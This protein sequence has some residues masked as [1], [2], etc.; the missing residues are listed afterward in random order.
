MSGLHGGS[1]GWKG[2]A[3]L[4]DSKDFSG[5]ATEGLVAIA[6]SDIAGQVR[7]KAFPADQL[8][9]RRRFGGGW[10]PSNVMINCFSRIAD[11]PFGPSGDLML[12]PAEDAGYRLDFGDGAVEHV[13]L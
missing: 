7:G 4:T 10:T 6:C 1:P 2:G 3:R 8:E 13:I 12:V 11:S 9:S 5:R